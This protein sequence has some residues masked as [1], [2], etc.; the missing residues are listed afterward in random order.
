MKI[1]KTLLIISEIIIF[2]FLY[3]YLF[4]I[5][6]NIYIVINSNI[7]YQYN[8]FKLYYDFGKGFNDYNSSL[9]ILIKYKNINKYKM[10]LPLKL[11]K[12]IK[13]SFQNNIGLI[14]INSITLENNLFKLYKWDP[15]K[16]F[17]NFIPSQGIN[18]YVFVKNNLYLNITENEPNLLYRYNFTNI[19]IFSIILYYLIPLLLIIIFMYLTIKILLF[20]K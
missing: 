9:P 15:K 11:I 18:G 5:N 12:K 7:N 14:K 16:I 1:L 4:L 6:K 2:L 3:F 17:Y 10:K 13:I 19:P 20:Y 8:Y